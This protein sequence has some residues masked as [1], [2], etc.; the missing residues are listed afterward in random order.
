[1]WSL[2]YP[3][4]AL[5]RKSMKAWIRPVYGETA[6]CLLN[7]HYLLLKSAVLADADYLPCFIPE[8]AC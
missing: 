7:L 5:S 1:M 6:S 4:C 2:A 3:F 8:V